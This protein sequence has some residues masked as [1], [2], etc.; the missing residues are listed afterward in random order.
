MLQLGVSAQAL[1]SHPSQ[2]GLPSLAGLHRSTGQSPRYDAG[3]AG[4]WFVD[5]AQGDD[6]NAG[7][8]P[9]AAFATIAAALAAA[10]ATGGAQTIRIMG[11]GHVFR[12]ANAL[13]WNAPALTDLTIT[14]YGTDRPVISG[15]RC[16]SGFAPC[17]VADAPLVGANFAQIR[18]LTVNAA[19]YPIAAHWRT[20]M[21]EDGRALT[22][23]GVRKPTRTTPDFFTD[24]I[25]QFFNANDHPDLAITTR[26]GGYYD[27]L[28][29]PSA[30]GAFTD[31]Q[32]AQSVAA[33]WRFGNG[34]EFLDVVSAINGTLTFG[35][36]NVTP[37]SGTAGAYALLNV[38]PAIEPG[39]WGYRDNGDGTVT[40]Y[41]W[42]SDPGTT[43]TEIAVASHGLRILRGLS[44]CS[45]TI[46]N[47]DFTMCAH[48]GLGGAALEI[49]NVIGL[50]GNP[51]SVRECSFSYCAG[52]SCLLVK[53]C[54]QGTTI[55]RCT[56][57]DSISFGLMTLPSTGRPSVGNRVRQCLA[58]DLS[59]TGFR[60]FGCHDMV[61]S[62]IH[63][64]RTSGGGHANAINFYGNCDRI[65]VVNFRGAIGVQSRL[66]E[67]Y[68][69]NQSASRLYFLHCTFTPASDGRGYVDQTHGGE[70]LPS[71]GADSHL[72]NCWVPHMPDR[73][74]SAN[75]GGITVGRDVHNW[76]V[77]NCVAPAIVNTGGT[78]TRASNLL[79][80]S[81][82]I[83]GTGEV[84]AGD[85][86][87]VFADVERYRFEAV[88]G[89]PL[90]TMTGA[91]VE[92]TIQTLEGWFPDEDFRRDAVGRAWDPA[93][94]G[95]GPY[96]GNWPQRPA[97][98]PPPVVL[99]QEL[100]TNGTFDADLS[101]WNIGAGFTAQWNGGVAEITRGT[102]LIAEGFKR[103]IP[104][105]AVGGTYELAFTISGTSTGVYVRG[106][107]A[108]GP[109]GVSGAQTR[110]FVAASDEL[111]MS[112]WGASG[113]VAVLDN[114]SLKRIA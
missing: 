64:V 100:V 41:I 101:G 76:T 75:A 7:T 80:N 110:Q 10:Y 96:A 5:G 77:T 73:L 38:L 108:W 22:L 102:G 14:G 97:K 33:V 44:N 89:S 88:P 27:T 66:Y 40:Y 71:V 93:N 31:A 105:L 29:H 17:T 112:F 74:G 92:S 57:R 52:E 62:D 82:V 109:A 65:A 15:A 21:T 16:L 53:F 113:S 70:V 98:P 12:E 87:A 48:S 35:P 51:A 30:L 81:S 2:R 49:N 111:T 47:I 20:I 11:D 86:D 94:P 103:V 32:L 95:V 37:Q 106:A 58:Q 18:K 84:L 6:G 23:C 91:S 50:A 85:V 90:N 63:A 43:E 60:M 39:E 28:T 72:I 114:V 3:T 68:A 26:T 99:G 25:N 59:Q 79:T 54:E 107:Y 45:V 83:A 24:N 67:G 4:D 56:F 13:S 34:T 61:M 78:V 1:G 8:T 69:T 104:D 36:A 19:D 9:A 55:E 46:E 42:P